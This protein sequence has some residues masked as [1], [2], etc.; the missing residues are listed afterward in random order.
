MINLIRN[1]IC[2]NQIN[3][4]NNMKNPI[5]FKSSNTQADSFKKSSVEENQRLVD[6]INKIGKENVRPATA[7]DYSKWVEGYMKQGV[8]PNYYCNTPL[9]E[10]TDIFLVAKQNFKVPK[11]YGAQAVNI[12][13]PEG[14]EIG[15]DEGNLGH[16]T[17]YFMED[18]SIKDAQNYYDTDDKGSNKSVTIYSDTHS[19]SMGSE[20]EEIVQNKWDERCQAG[21]TNVCKGEILI[22]KNPAKNDD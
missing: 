3:S 8:E 15:L 12:I 2:Q 18:F 7:E 19:N 9:N 20:I 22:W 6:T 13:V 17:L 11:L 14:I 4:I 5:C 16:S 10:S 21:K 1:N